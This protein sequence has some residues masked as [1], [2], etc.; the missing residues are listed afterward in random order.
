MRDGRCESHGKLAGSILTL[1]RAV[2]N[3]MRFAGV[4]FQNSLRMATLNPARA[5][6]LQHCKGAL[7][8]GADADVVVFS[9]A[10]EVRQ[11]IVGG[12]V[13]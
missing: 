13:D 1:D 12:V 4:S 6:G 3:T 5:L 9:P 2:R 11:T 7:Q 10:G 8:V